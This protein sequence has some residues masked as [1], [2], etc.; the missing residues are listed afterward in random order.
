MQRMTNNK[1]INNELYIMSTGG[2][3]KF[4]SNLKF[5]YIVI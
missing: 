2:M 4:K 5:M 1:T 3:V